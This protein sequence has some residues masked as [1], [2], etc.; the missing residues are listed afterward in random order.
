MTEQSGY[1]VETIAGKTSVYPVTLG[2]RQPSPPPQPYW[3]PDVA[4][5]REIARTIVDVET[6]EGR[7]LLRLAEWIEDEEWA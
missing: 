5:L 2:P 4:Y 1:L 3:R 6:D 7:F